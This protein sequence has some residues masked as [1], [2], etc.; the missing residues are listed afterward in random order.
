MKCLILVLLGL[1]LASQALALDKAELDQRLKRLTTKFEILQSKPDKRIPAEKLRKAQGIVL[2]DRTKAGFVF[3]YQGGGGVAMVKDAKSGKWSAPAFLRSNEGSLGL[4]VGGQQ[5]FI[6]VL[7][8]NTNTVRLLTEST[9]KFGGEASGTAG[10]ASGAAEGTVGSDEQLTVVYS[11][12]EGFYGGVAVKGG[13]VSPDTDAN[14]TYYGEAL[15]PR[16]ILFENKVK[17]TEAAVK[18]AQKITDASAR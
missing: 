7:I 10:N 15:T 14:V 1:G 5:A 9:F 11:D 3:A 8:M 2:L 16:E 13:A 4:Q 17:P 12:V 18:L 6:A